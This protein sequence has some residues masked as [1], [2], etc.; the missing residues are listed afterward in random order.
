[1]FSL[2]K[3]DTVIKFNL[4]YYAENLTIDNILGWIVFGGKCRLLLQKPPVVSIRWID[5]L[6]VFTVW[7]AHRETIGV[8]VTISF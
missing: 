7:L 2:K 3:I 4:N 1:M 6:A 5:S 8:S